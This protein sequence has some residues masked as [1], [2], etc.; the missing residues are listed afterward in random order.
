[1]KVIIYNQRERFDR[2]DELVLKLSSMKST[3]QNNM[4]IEQEEAVEFLEMFN[5][6]LKDLIVFRAD[7]RDH[8]WDKLVSNDLGEKIDKSLNDNY[9][10]V[11]E[12]LLL[13]YPKIFME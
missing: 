4:V 7:V 2:F 6:R 8:F 3:L 5:L 13:K 10:S 11:S 9:G 12:K 1:M